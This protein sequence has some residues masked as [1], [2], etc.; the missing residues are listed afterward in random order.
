MKLTYLSQSVLPSER[1]N[2]VQVMQMCAAFAEAGHAVEL[3]AKSGQD[4]VDDVFSH[5]GVPET[6][7]ITHLNPPAFKGRSLVMP[8]LAASATLGVESDAVFSRHVRAAALVAMRGVPVFH[9][10]HGLPR[11]RR[12]W[13]ALQ[14]L[15][16]CRRVAWVAISQALAD[17][18]R[19]RFPH[20][21]VHVAHDAAPADCALALPR[22]DPGGQLTVGYIGSHYPGRGIGLVLQLAAAFPTA[23]FLLVG[24][25]SADVARLRGSAPRNVDFVGR[26][27]PARALELRGHCDVLLA[28]YSRQVGSAGGRDTTQWMSPLKVFE[29]LASGRPLICSD[30]AVLQE[31][32]KDDRN[33]VLCPPDAF[34][35]WKAAL[36]RLLSD[37]SLRNRIARQAL[38]D[39]EQ[40]HTWDARAAGI[41]AFMQGRLDNW[42]TP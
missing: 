29:S 37:A 24:G 20:A 26:V 27:S 16:R 38:E 22:V 21:T 8:V 15:A 1:A 12:D 36:D 11:S 4:K 30:H 25:S 19:S 40:R 39:F 23:K 14:V 13:L 42:R 5:Y 18:F 31:V 10:L 17:A 33:A 32:L 2:S 28:P 41:L 9:E 7:G 3:I 35:A 34:E 6:F